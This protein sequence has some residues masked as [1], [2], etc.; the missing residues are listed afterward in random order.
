MI[1]WIQ[2]IIIIFLLYEHV[3]NA[4]VVLNAL[5]F[6]FDRYNQFYESVIQ[7]FNNYA[8]ATNLDIEIELKLFTGENIGSLLD[9]SRSVVESVLKRKANKYDIYFYETSYV[10]LYSPYLLDLNN[11]LS[12]EFVEMYDSRVIS[13]LCLF[14][15]KLIGIP[16]F[17]LYTGFYYNKPLLKKYNKRAPKTWDEMIETGKYILS[18]ERK[19]NNTDLTGFNGL[20]DDS[21]QGTLSILEFIY[22]FRDSIEDGFPEVGS[23]PFTD[24]LEMIKKNKKRIV[25][26][27]RISF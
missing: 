6:N 27:Y 23:K 14:N 9:D 18:E 16:I 12:Y 2:F 17:L 11:Y 5:A 3:G 1:I 19:K 10:A 22:S 15:N 7:Q 26:R 24:A 20:F 25:I 21:D 8:N 4:K 13:E